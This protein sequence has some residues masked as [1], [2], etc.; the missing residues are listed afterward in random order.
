MRLSDF[1]QHKLDEEIG[2][3]LDKRAASS[4]ITTLIPAYGRDYKSKRA[5]LEAWDEFKD[6]LIY[7]PFSPDDGRY[8]AKGDWYDSKVRIRY[9]GKRKV[10][11]ARG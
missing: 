5:V 8:T 4:H 3:A 9:D 10:V 11:E 7:D 2:R 1:E 6:F